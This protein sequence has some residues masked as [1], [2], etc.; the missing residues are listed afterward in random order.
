MGNDQYIPQLQ[1]V[2]YKRTV[3]EIFILVPTLCHLYAYAL[4]QSLGPRARAHEFESMQKSPSNE[5]FEYVTKFI[6][7]LR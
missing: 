3:I 5:I 1:S 2:D 6:V 7:E 4:L